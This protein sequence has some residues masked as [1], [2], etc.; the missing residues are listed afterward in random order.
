MFRP[1][2]VM[3]DMQ[4]VAGWQLDN[5]KQKGF[6]LP[7]TN[8][9]YATAYAGIFELGKLDR[10]GRWIP[11]LINIGNEEDWNT[12]KHRFF[13]DDYC[14]GQTYSNLYILFKQQK[15]LNTFIGLAD[16]ILAQ[17]HT[18]SLDWKNQIS[19]RE[20]A[21]CDALFM[22]PPALSYLSTATENEKYLNMAS[23]L[24]WKTTDFLYDTAQHLFFRDASFFQKREKNGEK[25]FWSRGNGW[26]MAGLVRML[27][28]MPENYPDKNKFIQLYKEMANRIASLQQADGTW[29]A[30]L[31]DPE[32]YPVKE[33]SGTGFY[34]YAIVWGIHHGLL[35][36]RKYWPVVEKAWSSL[37][38]CI[39][40]NGML[41][42]VQ[43]VG[44]APDQV[45]FD[46]TETYGTG[47]FLLAGSELYQYLSKKTSKTESPKPTVL[48]R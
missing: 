9:T 20:W 14:I 24:W 12:G 5:W 10:E 41:G 23:K 45:D 29:H 44:A 4:K 34:V 43:A 19:E 39:H 25:V 18:E 26:V 17:P 2:Q 47:A 27:Q 6:R 48:H 37:V 1:T 13:A 21:W 16:S 15:M 3:A 42:Y 30:S 31:L 35:N 36:K 32:S 11:F 28:N 33:T 38:N 8:W 22:G 40:E 7:K 46:S